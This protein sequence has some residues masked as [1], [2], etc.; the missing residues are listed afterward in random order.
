MLPGVQVDAEEVLYFTND[1]DRPMTLKIYSYSAKGWRDDLYFVPQQHLRP[2]SFNSNALYYML[3]R[4]DRGIDWP[5]GPYNITKVRERTGTY[6]EVKL[7]VITV[8][9]MCAKVWPPECGCCVE[10]NPVMVVRS[11]DWYRW[12]Q[13]P[14]EYRVEPAPPPAIIP[15]PA[16]RT[17]FVRVQVAGEVIAS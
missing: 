4:D 3:L 13:P 10:E 5:L 14:K 11:V 17:T 2:V 8:K 6:L 15:F 7:S 12:P 1:T 16:T 9:T